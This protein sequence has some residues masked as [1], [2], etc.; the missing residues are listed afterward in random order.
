MAGSQFASCIVLA[1]EVV[2][3]IQL[4]PKN[5]AESGRIEQEKTGNRN[6]PQQWALRHPTAWLQPGL[7]R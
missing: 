4:L 5:M 1:A 7:P 2:N 3:G 6:G